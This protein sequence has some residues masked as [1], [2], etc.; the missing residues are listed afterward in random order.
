MHTYIYHMYLSTYLMTL[1]KLVLLF[2]LLCRLK[3]CFRLH[4][5]KELIILKCR[6][7][8][9]E[10]CSESLVLVMA[11]NTILKTVKQKI[12]HIASLC[13]LIFSVITHAFS[14]VTAI[15]AAIVKKVKTILRL[16]AITRIMQNQGI[17]LVQLVVLIYL[18]FYF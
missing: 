3:C 14:G 13:L 16:Q 10:Y 1:Q 9:T 8:R 2:I 11:F 12:T 5:C 17:G 7:L 4:Q 6:E 18:T 15:I